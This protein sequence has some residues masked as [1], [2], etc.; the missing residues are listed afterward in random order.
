MMDKA[1]AYRLHHEWIDQCLECDRLTEWEEEFVT[2]V[3]EQLEKK[4][5]LSE[6]QVEILERIY[7]DRTD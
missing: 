3:K 7:A 1:N 2:S 6:K 4:G 5:S